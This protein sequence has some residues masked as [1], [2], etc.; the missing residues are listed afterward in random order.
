[1]AS[2]WHIE[3]LWGLIKYCEYE[4]TAVGSDGTGDYIDLDGTLAW[5]A[6]EGGATIPSG[7]HVFASDPASFNKTAWD[8]GNRML[9]RDYLPFTMDANSNGITDLEEDGNGP[10]IWRDAQTGPTVGAQGWE[11]VG[12]DAF[13][14]PSYYRT[15]AEVATFLSEAFHRAGD[16]DYNSIVNILD[17]SKIA[18]ALGTDSTWPPG[19]DWDQWNSNAD[20]NQD[21]VCDLSDLLIA[22]KNYGKVSG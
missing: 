18:R 3:I 15:Q 21:N 1:M 7:A 9:V 20:L 8:G 6:A 10:W 14:A 17:L 12:F 13:N 2:G 19:I 11:Y 16:V 22:G 5:S 4:I